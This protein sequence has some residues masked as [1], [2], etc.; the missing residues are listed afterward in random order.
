[1]TKQVA[2][3]ALFA[4]LVLVGSLSALA[5][6]LYATASVLVYVIMIANEQSP[7]VPVGAIV[8][9]ALSVVGALI[10][11]SEPESIE[12][13]REMPGPEGMLR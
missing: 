5:A 10:A 3:K 7:E 2:D 8:V 9:F 4:L 13:A 12:P 6:S 1:M 11:D